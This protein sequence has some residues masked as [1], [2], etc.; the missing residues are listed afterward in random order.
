M[1]SL[2]REQIV[3]L[4]VLAAILLAC[5]GGAGAGLVARHAAAREH[6]DRRDV[7]TKLEA[8]LHNETKSRRQ[9]VVTGAPDDA[10]LAAPTQGAAGAALEAYLARVSAAHTTLVSSA[11]RPAAEGDRP[12]VIRVEATLDLKADALQDLLYR[13]EMDEPYV[14]IDTLQL[15]AIGRTEKRGTADPQLRLTIGLH[16]AWRRGGS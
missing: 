2:S 15:R 10:F 9:I 4:G 16:A 8:R 5:I 14:F 6:A 11:V 12:E 3:A 13:L 7:L 1:P